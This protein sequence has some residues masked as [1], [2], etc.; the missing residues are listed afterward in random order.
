MPCCAHAVLPTSVSSKPREPLRLVLA[1]G[2]TPASTLY[3][4][5]STIVETPAASTSS[6]SSPL[7]VDTTLPPAHAPTAPHRQQSISPTLSRFARLPVGSR[8]EISPASWEVARGMGQLLSGRAGGAGLVVDYGD[9]KAFG[10]SWRVSRS[11]TKLS[12]R[13]TAR[14]DV[15]TFYVLAGLSETS[16]R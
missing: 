5:L 6:S 1:P 8:M 10:R 2:P 14:A 13:G 12:A 4:R 11:L 16:G 3:T 7:D 9:A 15:D